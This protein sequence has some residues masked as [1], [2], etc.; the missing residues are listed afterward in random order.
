MRKQ[1]ILEQ[2]REQFT[3]WES[4][5]RVSVVSGAQCGCLSLSLLLIVE[6]GIEGIGAVEINTKTVSH[7]NFPED[8]VGPS[9]QL[10][11]YQTPQKQVLFGTHNKQHCRSIFSC[12]LS[13]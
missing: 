10:T 12:F 8:E 11:R 13:F 3:I 1:I 2:S 7:E 6:T 5:C 4:G 9:E